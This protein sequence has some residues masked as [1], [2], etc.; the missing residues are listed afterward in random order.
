MEGGDKEMR[1]DPA[2]RVQLSVSATLVKLVKE[3][4]GRGGLQHHCSVFDTENTIMEK[5]PDCQLVDHLLTYNDKV[6]MNVR[7]FLVVKGHM[8]VS[9][10]GQNSSLT[11]ILNKECM[12]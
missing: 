10:A 2:V 8:F 11:L 7:I 1:R 4:N 9:G 12:K 6:T 5:G 3:G